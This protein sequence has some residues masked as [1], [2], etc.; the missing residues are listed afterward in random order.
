MG[1]NALSKDCI[2][3]SMCPQFSVLLNV[4]ICDVESK[5]ILE[6]VKLVFDHIPCCS[7]GTLSSGMLL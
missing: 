4:G 6:I 7:N 3:S 5:N 2:S 1:G